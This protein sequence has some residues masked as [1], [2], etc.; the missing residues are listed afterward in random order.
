MLSADSAGSW[1]F[2]PR[3][4]RGERRCTGM[5]MTAPSEISIHALREESDLSIVQLPTPSV[6]ISIH[7]LREESDAG[8]TTRA[9][10]TGN[11]NPRPPRGERLYSGSFG[12]KAVCISIHALRE[13]SDGSS[14]RCPSPSDH[15]NP[16]PPRGERH[17]PCRFQAVCQTISIHALREESDL[18]S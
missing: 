17:I 12:R 8:S 7:A 1:Y 15:F 16:R 6:M 3:P 13:E 5:V 2:N 14:R 9:A 11:F 4:P 18:K 10:A